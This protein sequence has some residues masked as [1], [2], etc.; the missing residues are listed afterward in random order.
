MAP[1]VTPAARLVS[2]VRFARNSFKRMFLE[3]FQTLAG[4]PA[5]VH[6]SSVRAD[7]GPDLQHNLGVAG[8]QG[9]TTA[10]T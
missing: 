1:P 6:E 10:F 2:T 5:P 8:G 3:S 4:S 7:P 9:G